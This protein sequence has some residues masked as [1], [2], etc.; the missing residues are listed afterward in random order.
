MI[1][2]VRLE[3]EEPFPGG[4]VRALVQASD[5]DGGSLRLRYA[6]TL[7]GAPV[8][9]DAPELALEQ[10]RKG[11]DLELTVIASDGSAESAPAHARTVL[12]NR[13]PLLTGVVLEPAE[14]LQ[15]GGRV[16]AVPEAQDPDDDTLRY[17]V[18]WRVNGDAVPGSGLEFETKG[19]RRGDRIQ[20][21]IRATDGNVTTE[22]VTS[23]DVQIGNSAPRIVSRPETRFEDGV[24]HY[25]V[26]AKD[27]DGDRNLRFSLLRAPAGM[28]IDRFDGAI[29]WAPKPEQ[30]GAH[31]VEVT[32][33]DSM[34][35]QVVQ[36]FEVT[37]G[38]EPGRPA[39]APLPAAP[40]ER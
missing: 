4:R 20:A 10:G 19:L 5:A 31:P 21:E 3:P 8:G 12:G 32:V 22:P 13:P 14:S 27:P 11:G 18:T 29:R 38:S 9:G 30:T 23:R 1:E 34:G 15:V 39:V 16:K 35:G 24:F 28:S 17:E 33:A 7:D 36:A 25:A 37:I 2:R 26:E 40:A 6:W